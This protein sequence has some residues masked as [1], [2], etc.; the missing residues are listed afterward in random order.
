MT[1]FIETTNGI[2]V[3]IDRIALIKERSDSQSEIFYTDEQGEGI[4]AKSY[5][6]ADYIAQ[7]ADV[8]IPNTTGAK[9]LWAELHNDG[10]S[11]W[12]SIE[13]IV[14]WRIS[15][16]DPAPITVQGVGADYILDTDGQVHDRQY[17]DTHD[18]IEALR[19][20]L[21]ARAAEKDATP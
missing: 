21:I 4:A 19:K 16:G 14:A 18:D 5:W 12:T 9:A 6:S 17:S 15:G 11:M 2:Y 10:L 13:P 1:K 8:V 3:A 7:C 20:A